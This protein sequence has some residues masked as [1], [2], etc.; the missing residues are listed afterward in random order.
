MA[1]RYEIK[2]ATEENIFK[3]LYVCKD[4][5]V[6]SLDQT[7]DLAEYAKKIFEKAVTFEAWSGGVLAG[8]IAVYFNDVENRTG[9]ITNVSLVKEYIGKGIANK[10]LDMCIDYARKNDF[11]EIKL[12]VKKNNEPAINLYRKNGF[13][14]YDRKDEAVFMKLVL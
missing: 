14:D 11:K 9:F 2:S 8:L 4:N 13:I 5:F 1:I 7:V 12:E 6:P 3:H 10:L